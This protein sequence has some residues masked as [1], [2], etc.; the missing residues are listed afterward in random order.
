MEPRLQAAVEVSRPAPSNTSNSRAL[1]GHG[2]RGGKP[3]RVEQ[4]ADIKVSPR[5]RNVTGSSRNASAPGSRKKFRRMFLA[6][7]AVS[8]LPPGL[9]S[10]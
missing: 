3:R 10:T 6:Q 9:R 8:A 1:F 7:R 2:L 5:R 4:D